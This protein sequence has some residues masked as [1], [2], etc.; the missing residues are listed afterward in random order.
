VQKNLV[1]MVIFTASL[2]LSTEVGGSAKQCQVWHKKMAKQNPSAR[3]PVSII[4]KGSERIHLTQMR[5]RLHESLK[6]EKAKS[7]A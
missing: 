4:T 1:D 3:R 5:K 7:T 6:A 2:F